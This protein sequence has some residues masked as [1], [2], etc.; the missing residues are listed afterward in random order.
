MPGDPAFSGDG[1]DFLNANRLGLGGQY[2]GRIGDRR[3]EWSDRHLA[4]AERYCSSRERAAERSVHGHINVQFSGNIA[5][6]CATQGVQKSQVESAGAHT[7]VEVSQDSGCKPIVPVQGKRQCP[8]GLHGMLRI[9]LNGQLKCG[10]RVPI[11][12]RGRQPLIGLF[13]D[14]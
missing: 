9:L 2:K 7:G 6:P 8:G 5:D 11:G 10:L 12:K 4:V 1:R 13:H 3:S 14:T